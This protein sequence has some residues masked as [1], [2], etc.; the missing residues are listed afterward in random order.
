M[1]LWLIGCAGDRQNLVALRTFR[2]SAG[3]FICS[4]TTTSFLR[5]A[6]PENVTVEERTAIGGIGIVLRS[7][8]EQDNA[9]TPSVFDVRKWVG[10]SW[11]QEDAIVITR[12]RLSFLPRSVNKCLGHDVTPLANAALKCSQLAVWKYS[13]SFLLQSVKN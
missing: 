4:T 7:A 3:K 12:H 1:F 10:A 13:W 5:V 2:L 9:G 11:M 8:A 6:S